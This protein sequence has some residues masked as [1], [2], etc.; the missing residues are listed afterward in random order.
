MTLKPLA[1]YIRSG[2][3]A[4]TRLSIAVTRTGS[5]KMTLLG[6]VVSETLQK[7]LPGITWIR[8]LRMAILQF[9]IT[10]KK[11]ILPSML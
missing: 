6:R 5:E 11:L 10:N 7:V 8:D 2:N 3:E 1:V 4:N 9:T